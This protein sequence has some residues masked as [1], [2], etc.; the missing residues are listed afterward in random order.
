MTSKVVLSESIW[1]HH[2]G[3]PGLVS[4]P[5]SPLGPVRA[6]F[7]SKVDGFVPHTRLVRLRTVGEP[8]QGRADLLPQALRSRS[9]CASFGSGGVEEQVRLLA[10]FPLTPPW[11]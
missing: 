2:F 6:R 7:R 8:E 10:T 1:A 3:A 4:V 5:D 9:K 11:R